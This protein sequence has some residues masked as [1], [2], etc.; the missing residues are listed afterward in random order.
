[1][2]GVWYLKEIMYMVVMYI[3]TINYRCANVVTLWCTDTF[4]YRRYRYTLLFSRPHDNVFIICSNM[5]VTYDY[6]CTDC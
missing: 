5:Y 2:Y 4:I 3:I 1:M 6:T